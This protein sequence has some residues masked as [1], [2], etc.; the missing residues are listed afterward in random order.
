MRFVV[1]TYGTE[2][3]TRPLAA[4]SRALIDAGHHVQLL[5]DEATLGSAV[6]LGIPTAPLTGD[7]KRVLQ[8]A[9][10]TRPA[11]TVRDLTQIANAN[12][13]S[14][15]REITAAAKGCDAVIVSALASFVGLSAAECLG[16]RAIGA[17]SI[18]ITPTAAF[19]SPFLPPA[20]VPKWLNKASH[21]FINS[22][23]WSLLRKKTNAARASVCRLPPRRRV[24]TNHPM[25]WGVS[26]TLL[27][28][29]ADYPA[30]T[31]ICGQWIA[32]APD[33]SPPRDLSEFLAAGPR[34]IY[35]GFGSM[36]GLIQPGLLE[37]L[38]AGIGG[39]RALFYPGWSNVQTEQLPANFFLVRDTPHSWLLPRTSLVVHH[40]GAGTTHSAAR[41]GV[42]SIVVPF[43]G[44]QPFWADRLRRLG[45]APA[46]LSMKRLRASE[47]EER[48]A[49]AERPDVRERAA[50]LGAR[51]S[52]EDGL[53]N[54]LSAIETLMAGG[55]RVA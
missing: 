28:R 43:A 19:A 29:P 36:A 54:A 2:G 33:W 9:R 21:G 20:L 6:S 17:G 35:I 3:D 13:E 41:A 46:P 4:L 47:L 32:P 26:P 23:I 44:D 31:F 5:A 1:A 10:K 30:N 40:G 42:P 11:E 49:F 53:A 38:I 50:A 25:I 51:M 12:T 15:L 7:I 18:P 39:R 52:S 55:T 24:F 16:I 37:E 22:T 45:V 14:W 34:P 8:P 48:L 27:P